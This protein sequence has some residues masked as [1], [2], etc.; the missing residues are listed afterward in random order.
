ME[1]VCNDGT[2]ENKSFSEYTPSGIVKFM[3]TNPN[4]KDEFKPGDTYYITME[5]EVH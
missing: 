3:L 1:A 2:E 5:K 4:C